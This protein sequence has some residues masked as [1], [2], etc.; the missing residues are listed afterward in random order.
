MGPGIQPCTSASDLQQV[1]KKAGIFSDMERPVVLLATIC[2][3]G[4]NARDG[5]RLLSD[6]LNCVKLKLFS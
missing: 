6:A 3:E 1:S 4:N 2:L 5:I